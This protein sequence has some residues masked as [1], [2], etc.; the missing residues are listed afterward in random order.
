L[1]SK[2]RRIIKKIDLLAFM[3]NNIRIE[4]PVGTVPIGI[5]FS[6]ELQQSGFPFPDKDIL[7]AMRALAMLNFRDIR[8]IRIT[9]KNKPPQFLILEPLDESE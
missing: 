6:N 3:R 7:P 9:G 8:R 4:N 1:I 2:R 5:E